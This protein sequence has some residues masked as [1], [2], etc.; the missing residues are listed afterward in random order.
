MQPYSGTET[1]YSPRFAVMVSA[2]L[3]GVNTLRIPLQ[4]G[5][6]HHSP[7]LSK[8][9]LMKPVPERDNPLAMCI[10][11]HPICQQDRCQFSP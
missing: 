4:S 6:R 3:C 2:P 11:M 1:R 10:W 9:N 5:D 8:N 7:P